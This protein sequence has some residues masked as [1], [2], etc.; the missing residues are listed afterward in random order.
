[1][2]ASCPVMPDGSCP[3]FAITAARLVNQ[4]YRHISLQPFTQERLVFSKLHPV[5]TVHRALA[6]PARLTKAAAGTGPPHAHVDAG[7][8]SPANRVVPVKLGS[9]APGHTLTGLSRNMPLA[10]VMSPPL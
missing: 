7:P 9:V 6:P 10:A 8:V 5:V 3:A 2:P 1:M 4:Y